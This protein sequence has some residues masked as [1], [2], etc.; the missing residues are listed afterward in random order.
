MLF[1]RIFKNQLGNI[2]LYV[3]LK[4]KV[5]SVHFTCGAGLDHTHVK[6][7]VPTESTTL[8]ASRLQLRVGGDPSEPE[9]NNSTTMHNTAMP[10]SK[11]LCCMHLLQVLMKLML[12]SLLLAAT[13]T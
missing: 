5:F 4:I 12:P 6:P 2:Q 8:S 1:N 13:A 10:H 9:E 11:D 3:L 7:I